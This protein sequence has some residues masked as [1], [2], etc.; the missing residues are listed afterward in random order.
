MNRNEISRREF[1]K[2]TATA[3]AGVIGAPAILS[4]SN[5]SDI[6]GIGQVGIGS[7]GKGLMRE[8]LATYKTQYRGVCEIYDARLQ[9]ALSKCQNPKAAAYRDYRYLLENKD[10]DAVIIGTPDHWHAR[11]AVDALNAGKDVYVEKAMTKTLAEAKAIVKAVKENKRVFQLGHQGRSSAANMRAKEIYESGALGPVTYVRTFLNR[12]SV[13]GEWRWYIDE[14]HVPDPNCTPE[15]VDWET[16][17][18]TA[19]KRSFDP[20]RY[21][22]WRCYWDYG[23]GLAGDLLSHAMD[24]VNQTMSL[25][26]PKTCVATGGIYY[27]DDGRDVPDVWN[28][29]YDWPDRK[30]TVNYYAQCNNAHFG[31]SAHYMGKDAAMEVGDGIRV[32]PEVISPRYKQFIDEQ[33]AKLPSGKRLNEKDI[34]PVYEENFGGNL[35]ITT[36]MEN[37]IDC[38]RSR[39]KCR[40]N[41]DIGFEEAVT[42][43]M[44]VKAYNEKRMVTWNPVRQEI[45]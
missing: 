29:T 40:C 19:P 45:V 41:E 44:S 1:L 7:R 43:H 6:I 39:G 4:A 20:L 2:D 14:N 10:I 8:A 24:A 42:V 38:V 16:F 36:H 35:A 32:Y 25:G 17:L 30:L 23:T 5:P 28:A 12:N 26:I 18:G 21:L 27:W 37:F 11:I 3:A 33:R 13:L 22:N 31:S 34:P 15:H 9:D